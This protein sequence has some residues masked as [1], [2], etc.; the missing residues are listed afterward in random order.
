M[1]NKIIH[2][3]S[4]TTVLLIN[5]VKHGEHKIIID[6]T[7]YPM[8]QHSTWGLIMSGHKLYVWARI[9]GK[10]TRMHRLLM[11][12]PSGIEVDHVNGDTFDN[13]RSSNLRLCTHHQNAMNRSK[14]I[15]REGFKGVYPRAHK[16]VAA[17]KLNAK[18][19]YLGIF[20]NPIDA[21]LAYNAAA[22][23]YHGEFARLN[24]L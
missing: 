8:I 22:I 19:I 6:T 20:S 14:N 24:E 13:R 11:S 16:H 21:A 3:D 9:G 2:Q 7:D 23:K 1:T 12:A 15:G 17:I 4:E 10:V 18:N 5:S